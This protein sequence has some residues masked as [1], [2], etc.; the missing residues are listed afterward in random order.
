MKNII[1]IRKCCANITSQLPKKFSTS[2]IPP[3]T[4]MRSIMLGHGRNDKIDLIMR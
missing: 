3:F 4:T 2:S 1:N